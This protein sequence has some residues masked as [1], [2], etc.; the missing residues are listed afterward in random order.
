M[1]LDFASEYAQRTDDE[2][3]LL[4]QDRDNL[5]DTARQAL[6]AEVRKRR[7]NGFQLHVREPEEPRIHV[8]ED[9]DDGNIVTVR[10]RDLIFP[11]VCPRCLASADSFVRIPCDGGSSWGLIPAVDISL[12][13]W[14]YLFHRYPVPFCR[15]CAVSVR[16]RR[17]V[18]RLFLRSG[19]GGCLYLWVRYHFSA[20]RFVLFSACAYLIGVGLWMILGVPKRWPPAG[21][22][23]LSGWSARDRRLAFAKPEYEKA[24]IALNGGSVRR[25]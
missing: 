3:R 20:G 6:D 4:I 23:V 9:D 1:N 2:L 13:L 24:F 25:R 12:G 19:C 22:E 15:S 10:S 16:L 8:E 14:R 7:R 5:V 18:E 17:G 21:I 11:K